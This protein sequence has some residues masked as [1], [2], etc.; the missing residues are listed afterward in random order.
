MK[1]VLVL[2]PSPWLLSDRDQPLTGALYIASF[3]KTYSYEVQV[4]DLAGVPEEYWH[5]P[6]GDAYGVTGTT[7]HF[8]YMKKIIEKL[9]A[10]EPNKPVIVGGVHASVLPGHVMNYTKADCCVV[11]E[12]EQAIVKILHSLDLKKEIGKVYYS[13]PV[14]N[15]D[16][17]PFPDR[18]SIDY[19]DYMVPQTYKYLVG[20][21]PVREASII[22]GRGCPYHCSYCAS[23]KL[24][25]GKVRFRSPENVY[26]EL[27]FL[28]DEYDIGLCNFI[29]D[30]FTLKKTRV[31]KICTL[32]KPLGIKW[33]CLSRTDTADLDLFKKMKKSGCLSIT[34]GFESGSDRVLGIINKKAYVYQSY[35]A[36]KMA[37]EAGLKIRGQMMVGLPR[38]TDEDVELTAQ[39][40]KKAKEV[41][42][43][44]LHVFQP[45]PGCDIWE[46]PKHYDWPPVN[47]DKYSFHSIGKPDEKLTD[48]NEVW[49][50]Y[51]YLKSIIGSR[52]IE[53]MK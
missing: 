32:I 23:F 9:K 2:P 37:K 5:V 29:D 1:F 46:N 45:Y 49:D 50:R 4:A 38:E 10:R 47:V 22:T 34:F 19:F 13:D 8:P 28:K 35:K 3:I 41:D 39:F 24:Y 21:A 53:E 42:T 11:G 51:L 7:P 48:D 33:F 40:I 15:L 25:G 26:S 44:G 20:Q 36:I 27:E 14:K 30:T 43:F 17:L 31:A 12:G 6:I 52:N 16:E 18:N